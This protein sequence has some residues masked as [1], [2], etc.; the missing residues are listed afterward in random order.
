MALLVLALR[1][2]LRGARAEPVRAVVAAGFA[3]LLL[4]TWAYAAFLEDPMAW[5]L[6]AIGTALA[7]PAAGAGRESPAEAASRNGRP[8]EPAVAAP[9]HT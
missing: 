2:L 4:H 3:A 6:L 5:T 1:R 9:A 7:L 8:R